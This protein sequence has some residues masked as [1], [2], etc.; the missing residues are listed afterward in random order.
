MVHLAVIGHPIAHSLSPT[1]HAS[2]LRASAKPG[3][4]AAYD[5]KPAGLQPAILGL[6]A[7]GFLGVNV[8]I[9]HKEAALA[10][11]DH[12][13][14]EAAAIGAV[15]TLKFTERGVEGYNTDGRGFL[16]SLGDW[17][18]AGANVLLL[19]AGGAA[20]AVAFALRNAGASRIGIVNRTPARAQAL[21]AELGVDGDV[22]PEEADLLVNCTS[23]GMAPN[24]DASPFTDW[25]RLRRSCLVYDLVYRPADTAFLQA[26]RSRG[27]MAVGG[28]AMLAHQ[29]A[30]AWQIWFGE[31]APIDA[32][33][34]AAAR[35]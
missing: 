9:P 34:E 25:G 3:S 4:Y 6:R 19:G 8:T 18:P 28:L 22:Q 30:L 31:P 16:A 29:A 17:S 5:V 21:M 35:A 24:A 26:A 27:L 23:V 12:V 7:L 1:L 32:F 2:A 20:R 15:N 11:C 10:F 14:P 13:D 33:L